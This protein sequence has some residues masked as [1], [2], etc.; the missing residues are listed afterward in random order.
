VADVGA[1]MPLPGSS[2][3][4]VMFAGPSVTLATHHFF[5]SEFGVTASESLA[6]GHPEFDPHAGLESAGIGFSSTKFFGDHWLLNL[7]AAFS[8]LLG[9]A[10]TSPIT[11]RSAQHVVTLSVNYR[12]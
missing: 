10:G 7:D 8:K 9:S 6:S 2:K 3:Q 4:F 11:E 1:Y 12:W 5:Q